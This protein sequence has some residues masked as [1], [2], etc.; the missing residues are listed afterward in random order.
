MI[1]LAWCTD[2]HLDCASPEILEQFYSEIDRSCDAVLITGDVS[3]AAQVFDHLDR[4]AYLGKTV[5]FNFGNHD[6]YGSSIAAIREEAK[7][8]YSDPASPI[9]YLEQESCIQL[10]AQTILLGADGWYDGLNGDYIRSQV[11]LNDFYQIAEFI[12][13][14]K[15]ERLVPMHYLTKCAA[16]KIKRD[17][18]LAVQVPG[19]S[20]ILVATH[21]PPFAGAAWH[22]GQ[23]STWDFLP[24]FS[25]K[26][27]GEAILEVAATTT[28]DIIVF[29]GHS[30][31]QGQIQPAMNVTCITGQAEY[32]RPS[33]FKIF[34]L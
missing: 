6:A 15:H 1:R 16:E 25:N 8:R 30:H 32:Y 20:T 7:K 18:E 22:I 21:F 29:C 4:F 12:G 13:L 34:N 33:I 17:L 9:K 2:T 31:S 3:N 27:V 5:Y 14:R 19:V 10:N 28:C 26:L 11:E 23:V 24:F